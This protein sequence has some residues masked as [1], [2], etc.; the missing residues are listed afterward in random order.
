MADPRLRLGGATRAGLGGM[1]LIRLHTGQFD[2]SDPGDADR[3]RALPRGIAETAGLAPHPVGDDAPSATTNLPKGWHAFTLQ[4]Q[5]RDFWRI[6]QGKTPVGE[7]Y[8]KDPD[9]LPVLEERVEWNNGQGK[10]GLALPLVPGSAV[11]G[12]LA[13]RVAYYANCLP[14]SDGPRWAEQVEE[15]AGWDKSDPEQGSEIVHELF[16][17]SR[18]DSIGDGQP[19]GQAGRIFIDDAYVPLDQ[20]Q[21][22][23]LMHNAIDRFTG[24]VRDRLLFSEELLWQTPVSLTCLVCSDGLEPTQRQILRAALEDLL[25]GRLALG[26]GDGKGHGRF[27]GRADPPLDTL[28]GIAEAAA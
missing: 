17:L 10:R 20:T 28:D 3:F 6:G 13:H 27:A 18:N 16:G 4:L 26:A 9:A 15:V 22:S 7:H 11:K 24:G 23:Q 8:A 14:G 12:A 19:I 1:A 2:L 21:A 5:A 25:A